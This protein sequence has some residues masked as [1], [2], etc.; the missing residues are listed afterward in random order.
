MGSVAL[1]LGVWLALGSLS[2]LAERIHLF[3]GSL[4]NS[5]QRLARIPRASWGMTLGHLGLAVTIIGMAGAGSWTIESIQVMSPRDKVEVGGYEFTFLGAKPSSGP[6]YSAITGNFSVRRHGNH[7][8][9][10]SAEKRIYHVS[11]QPTTEAAIHTTWA[12]DLYAVIG[13]PDGKD[14]A[15]VTRLYFN[16]LVIW[17]WIGV[18]IM[19]LAGAISLTD[20]RHRIGSPQQSRITT[21]VQG[22]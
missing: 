20:R 13:E 12:G 16:P 5:L 8:A 2:E 22:I 14:G 19:V 17:M 1:A 15:F 6:N 4:G 18:L 9:S 21:A 11:Q 10:L 3:K 7:I